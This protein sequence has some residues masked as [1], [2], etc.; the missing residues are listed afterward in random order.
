[1][2]KEER[3]HYLREAIRFKQLTFY[4]AFNGLKPSESATDFFSMMPKSLF[5]YR[6]FDEYAR[7]MINESYLY[8]CPAE[9]LDDPFECL[10]DLDITDYFDSDKKM[11]TSA[12]YR[13]IVE[14]VLQFIPENRKE[15]VREMVYSCTNPDYTLNQRKAL[16]VIHEEQANLPGVD[17]SML[18]NIIG[19]LP[20]RFRSPDLQE[21]IAELLYSAVN[22]RKGIG[23]CSL[24]ESPRS[25]VMWA[26]Y[27]DNYQGYCIEYD[28]AHS[29]EAAIDTFP[30]VYE[31]GRSNNALTA[32]LGMFINS[33]VNRVTDGRM[34]KDQTQYFRLLLTKNEEWS[35]QN[36][37]RVIRK[38]RT[39]VKAPPIKAIYIGHKA[40]QDDVN[41]ILE[42]SKAHGFKV[43]RT[44]VNSKTL[45]IEFELVSDRA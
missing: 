25:Q 40:K 8:L 36:E 30:V 12:C 45:G 16:D 35:F 42:L 43:Y 23:I 9:E 32:I 24:A 38:A 22:A 14:M 2:K 31:D 17:I 41:S 3:E 6:K 11:I 27:G 28:F 37:W 1:M 33:A 39:K 18:V 29:A 13:A 44:K 19:S 15:K 21:Q 7:E 10:F 20:N 5:K 26:M 34:G 4:G